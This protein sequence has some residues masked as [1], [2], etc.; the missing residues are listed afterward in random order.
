MNNYLIYMIP[1][2]FT[3]PTVSGIVKKIGATLQ[4]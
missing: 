3:T 2:D 4:R 1:T